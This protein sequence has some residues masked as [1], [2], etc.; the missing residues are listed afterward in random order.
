[1][2]ERGVTT[3]WEAWK[4]SDNFYTNCHPTENTLSRF[5]NNW[6]MS[7]AMRGNLCRL[8]SNCDYCV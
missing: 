4:E 7:L 1:M 6:R 5:F 3:L 2:I 8:D